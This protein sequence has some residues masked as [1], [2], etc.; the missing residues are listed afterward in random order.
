LIKGKTKYKTKM[1]LVGNTNVVQVTT[2]THFK[3]ERAPHINRNTIATLQLADLL[4]DER[5]KSVLL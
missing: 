2:K 5:D 1:I 4:P 3:V